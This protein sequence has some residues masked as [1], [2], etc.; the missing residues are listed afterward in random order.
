VGVKQKVKHTWL[1]NAVFAVAYAGMAP[2]WQAAFDHGYL[3]GVGKA[4]WALT[5]DDGTLLGQRRSRCAVLWGSAQDF[6]LMS[7]L[8]NLVGV[9]L[10]RHTSRYAYIK[11]DVSGT[12]NKP[13]FCRISPDLT[14]A[15][16]GDVWTSEFW[17]SFYYRPGF[18]P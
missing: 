12:W 13:Y 9:D 2:A 4:G 14:P 11:D 1:T 7:Y 10:W 6:V 16:A 8:P 5:A 15:V 17:F 3:T 18:A